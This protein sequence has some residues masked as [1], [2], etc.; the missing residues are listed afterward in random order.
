MTRHD[1]ASPVI[2]P[3][4]ATG[5]YRADLVGRE[6]AFGPHDGA[7]VAVASLLEHAALLPEPERSRLVVDAV[8]FSREMIGDEDIGR[9]G[10]REW[11]EHDRTP[12][13][14][15][16]LLADTVHRA[17]AL[18]IAGVMLDALLVA[19][20]SLNAVQRGRIISQRARVFRK[21]GLIDEALEYDRYVARLGRQHKSVELI[22]RASL[23]FMTLAQ[24]RGNYPDMHRHSARAARMAERAGFKKLTRDGRIGLM[25]ALGAAHRFDEALVNGWKVYQSSVGHLVDENEVLQNIGQLLFEAGHFAEARAGFAAVVSR[26]LPAHIILPALGGLALASAA[27]GQPDTVEWAASEIERLAGSTPLRY[28]IASALLESATGLHRI[29]RTAQAERH[30]LA[31]I[32]LG[33]SHNFHEIVFRAEALEPAAVGVPA[34]VRRPLT[35]EAATVANE[36]AWM[37]PKRLPAHVALAI[38]SS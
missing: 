24:F 15:I 34:A 9:L 7:W 27:T 28:P 30:R 23:G 3:R 32:H 4:S 12:V 35:K 21:L 29:G 6:S 13:E 10:E 38:A 31:A 1:P 17:G 26:E 16:M 22:V 14:A 37:E 8:E 11:Q 19:D 5:A 36:V 2:I 18:H 25:I 20:E 33:K